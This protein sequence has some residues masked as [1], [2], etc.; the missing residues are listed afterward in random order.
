MGIK[1]YCPNGHK[2]NVKSFLA[3]RRGICPECDARFRIPMESGGVA[4]LVQKGERGGEETQL[5][6]SMQDDGAEA[7]GSY[8]SAASY[9]QDFGSPLGSTVKTTPW[10]VDTSNSNP[11]SPAGASSAAKPMGSYP[12]AAADPLTEDPQAVWYVRPRSGGQYGPAVGEILR[13]WIREGRVAGDSY[14]WR[15]GWT[16]WRPAS[17]VFPQL[18]GLLTGGGPAAMAAPVGAG[19]P[20]AGSLAVGGGMPMGN[21]AAAAGYPVAGAVAS[22]GT[23]A[24]LGTLPASGM[25]ALE[26]SSA[27]RTLP[28]NRRVDARRRNGNLTALIVV[29]LVVVAI[30]LVGVFAWVLF[31][32]PAAPSEPASAAILAPAVLPTCTI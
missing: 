20:M 27:P 31:G 12:T 13:D 4:E 19:L 11:M 2:L 24:G 32:K 8:P 26:S 25:A 15:E 9:G 3:G 22:G 16:D 21:V 23:V 29:L 1:F 14:V 7:A 6:G 18:A 5:T 30:V 28:A 10:S 17:S